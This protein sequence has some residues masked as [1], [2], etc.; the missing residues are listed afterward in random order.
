MSPCCF[1]YISVILFIE[2]TKELHCWLRKK[3]KI[4]GTAAI[5]F[6]KSDV[7]AVAPDG[8]LYL[9]PTDDTLR[10]FLQTIAGGNMEE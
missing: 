9:S 6:T 10:L 4:I 3:I 8:S 7:K 1:S 5:F 2:S